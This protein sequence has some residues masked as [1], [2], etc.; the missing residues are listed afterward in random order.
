MVAGERAVTSGLSTP[1]MASAWVVAHLVFTRIIQAGGMIVLVRFLSP[2]DFGAWAVI[3]TVFAVLLLFSDMG[4]QSSLIQTQG[5]VE[6]AANFWFWGGLVLGTACYLIV[7]SVGPYCAVFFHYPN[8]DALLRVMGVSLLINSLNIVPN[9]L[10]VR[11]SRFRERFYVEGTATVVGAGVSLATAAHGGGVW[12]L[13]A[14]GLTAQVLQGVLVYTVTKWRPGRYRIPRREARQFMAFGSAVSLQGLLVWFINNVDN[15][16]IGRR[17]GARELGLYSLGCYVGLLPAVQIT[18]A[19]ATAIYPRMSAVQP[20]RLAVRALY[21]GAMR[22]VSLV[23]LPLGVGMIVTAPLFVPL[24]FGDAWD[25][26][27]ALIQLTAVYGMLASVGGLMVPLCNSQGRPDIVL[28]YCVASAAMA[29]PAYFFVVPYGV[30][31]MAAAHVI[32]A[33]IRFPVDLAIAM[34][35]LGLPARNLWDCLRPAIS[36]AAAIGLWSVMAVTISGF[37]LKSSDVVTLLVTVVGSGFVY[38]LVLRLF[39]SVRFELAL[40]WRDLQHGLSV[41]RKQSAPSNAERAA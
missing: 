10:L 36:A 31:A 15:I 3:T 24:W 16:L 12:S 9:A 13:V 22:S 32:L 28:K 39:P 8:L 6:A 19:A 29:I 7:F 17:W 5:D 21:L 30:E 40:V 18:G 35:L 37:L 2:S 27:I 25:G 23:T 26:A 38:G 4:V 14:G 20:D 11:S 33:S 34:A 41:G 1:V